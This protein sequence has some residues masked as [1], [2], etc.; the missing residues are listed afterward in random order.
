MW[1]GAKGRLLPQAR[2]QTND[3]SSP[4]ATASKTRKTSIGNTILEGS[5]VV[6]RKTLGISE[7]KPGRYRGVTE[8]FKQVRGGGEELHY[9]VEIP[10]GAKRIKGLS[11]YPSAFSS[12]AH[13]DIC[14]PGHYSFISTSSSL[15]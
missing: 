7:D 15:R 14:V 8:E 1:R 9:S 5:G 3:V 2:F 4:R 10:A 11:K 13:L 6:C 12:A